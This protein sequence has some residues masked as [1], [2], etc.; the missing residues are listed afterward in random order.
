MEDIDSINF[1][2]QPLPDIEGNDDIFD[3]GPN[4]EDK[5]MTAAFHTRLRS[6]CHGHLQDWDFAN[7]SGRQ[8]FS[9]K[10]TQ[11]GRE[12][13]YGGRTDLAAI[14]A[15][16]CGNNQSSN[17]TI[18]RNTRMVIELKTGNT[19]ADA[20]NQMIGELLLALYSSEKQDVHG[21]LTSGSSW[22]FYWLVRV[23]NE[24]VIRRCEVQGWIR[25]VRHLLAML[26]KNLQNTTRL[27]P[28][29]KFPSPLTENDGGGGG[30][31]SGGGGSGL[32]EGHRRDPGEDGRDD[33]RRVRPRYGENNDAADVVDEADDDDLDEI[34]DYYDADGS[35]ELPFQQLMQ[36]VIRATQNL[37]EF[38]HLRS[39]DDSSRLTEKSLQRVGAQSSW[40][41]L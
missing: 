18:V 36:R 37:P 41:A 6:S 12:Y 9:F 38:A 34:E 28:L 15:F 23:G 32:N 2:F 29:Q 22:K 39:D 40:I 11:D 24:V 19:Y 8:L 5:T 1:D 27:V 30:G 16:I 26:S 13:H 7:V 35:N 4:G 3:W 20:D 25:G 17:T 10:F 21:V 14:P 33:S 31:G